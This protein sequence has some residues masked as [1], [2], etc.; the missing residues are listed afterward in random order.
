ML[1]LSLNDTAARLLHG[2]AGPAAAPTDGLAPGL[3]ARL[4]G[5]IVRRGPVLT[6]ADSPGDATAAPGPHP[7]LTGWECADS[8]LHLTDLV[9]VEV[10]LVD[11]VPQLDPAG[12]R[13]LLRQGL[14]LALGFGELVRG[15]GAPARVRCVL[16]VNETGG[17]FRFHQV[18]AGE[19]WHHP[20]LD[21]YHPEAV[22]VLEAAPAAG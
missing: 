1:S 16:G 19:S 17:T 22:C 5:G 15:L 13:L 21:G 4:A 3:R 18:R 20:D 14:G 9:P 6:W 10:A 7:D 2:P 12:Q 8:A 11:D